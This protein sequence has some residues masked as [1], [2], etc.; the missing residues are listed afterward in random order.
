M[1]MRVGEGHRLQQVADARGRLEVE[2]GVV[3][4]ARERLVERDGVGAPNI[5]L[6]S[7]LRDAGYSR[8]LWYMPCR[9]LAGDI[10]RRLINRRREVVDAVA[11]VSCPRVL[12]LA[13]DRGSTAQHDLGRF[14]HFQ[15]L[16]GRTE[17]NPRTVAVEAL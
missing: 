12:A 17:P 3:D 8:R 6:V 11:Q 15:L 4:R 9:I 10:E 7:I 14:R 1:V 5:V 13:L 16:E 2:S